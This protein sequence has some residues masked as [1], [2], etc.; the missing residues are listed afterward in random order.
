MRNERESG[1]DKSCLLV[2]MYCWLERCHRCLQCVC[3]RQVDNR[4]EVLE[5]AGKNLEAMRVQRTHFPVNEKSFKGMFL[6]VVSSL[7]PMTATFYKFCLSGTFSTLDEFNIF[8]VCRSISSGLADLAGELMRI[9]IARISNGEI[10][11][12]IGFASFSERFIGELLLVVPQIDGNYD[13]KSKTE[14]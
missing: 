3:G 5:K 9:A 1:E 13:M 7:Y 14:V 6:E 2:S 8:R 4:Y 10:E 12:R 11:L